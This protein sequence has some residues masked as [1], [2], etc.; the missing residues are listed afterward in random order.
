MSMC[1]DLHMPPAVQQPIAKAIA[2]CVAESS[3]S[4]DFPCPIARR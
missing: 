2:T 1:Q 4:L 3:G